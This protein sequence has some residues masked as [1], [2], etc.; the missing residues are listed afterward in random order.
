MRS[1]EEKYD[2]KESQKARKQERK[3]KQ[4]KRSFFTKE[5]D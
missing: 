2:K 1:Y 4:I 5:A 3:G